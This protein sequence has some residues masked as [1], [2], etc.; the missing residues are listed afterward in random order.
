MKKGFTLIE[1][2]VVVLIIGI[3]SAIAL[4]QYEKAVKKARFTEDVTV[5]NAL[6]KALDLYVLANGYPERTT[7]FTGENNRETR[8]SAVADISIPWSS[9][10]DDAGC[11]AKNGS[12][13]TAYCDPTTCSI[14]LWHSTSIGGSANLIYYKSAGSVGW[15]FGSSSTSKN[16]AVCR[17]VREFYGADKMDDT[18][19]TYCSSQGIE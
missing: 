11:Y 16:I 1:L 6:S 4:P 5:F 15:V 2:L 13:W 14:N 12:M 8:L 9:C 17:M 19:K 3:L 7:W 10:D 18:L